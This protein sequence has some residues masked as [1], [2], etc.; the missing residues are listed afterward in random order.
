VDE[1]LVQILKQIITDLQQLMRAE[2][3]LAE[4]E[5]STKMSRTLHALVPVVIGTV[6]ALAALPI[7]L[8]TIS[9][10]LAIWLPIWASLLLVT[11]VALGSSGAAI[12]VGLRQLSATRP[13]PDRTVVN[14]KRD[15][16]VIKEHL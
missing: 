14:L 12:M 16:D 5:I 15:A 8:F 2:F 7:L 3:A 1:S 9:V 4:S 10:I 6:L 11:V 13:I